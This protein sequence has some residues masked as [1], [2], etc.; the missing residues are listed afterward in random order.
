MI[1][2]KAKKGVGALEYSIAAFIFGLLLGLV[3]AKTIYD[4]RQDHKITVKKTAETRLLSPLAAYATESATPKLDTRISS[5][6]SFLGKYNST[7]AS[8]S[9][10]II[11]YSDEYNIDYKII[12]AIAGIESTFCKNYPEASHNCFGYMNIDGNGI[13]LF[14][15]FESAIRKVAWAIGTR[16]QFQEWRDDRADFWKL[17]R[18]YNGGDRK[19]WQATLEHF[20]SEQEAGEQK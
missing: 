18:V 17:A 13:W 11:K 3:F 7:L 19:K 15:D 2:K 16:P 10:L 20:I 9:A 5:T 6:E 14:E 4:Y 1:K 12:P 8:S